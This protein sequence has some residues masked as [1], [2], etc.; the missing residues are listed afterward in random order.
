M[1]D[2]NQLG[3]L[4]KHRFPGQSSRDS[5]L[6]GL[7]IDWHSC[8]LNNH[9]DVSEIGALWTT[10]SIKSIDDIHTNWAYWWSC[11]IKAVPRKN[12]SQ[13][14]IWEPRDSQIFIIH[15]V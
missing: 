7:L 14:R 4:W 10:L 6:V 3:F 2:Q 13:H 1:Y 11:P 15:T 12:S 8:L 9:P 5:D